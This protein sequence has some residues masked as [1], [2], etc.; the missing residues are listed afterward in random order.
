[1][2]WWRRTAPDVELGRGERQLDRLAFADGVLAVATTRRLVIRRPG[3]EDWARLWWQVEAVSVEAEERL[4]VVSDVEADHITLQLGDGDQTRFAAT[5]RERVQATLVDH[6]QLPVPGGSVRVAL[7]KAEG[8]LFLQEQWMGRVD[9]E[10]PRTRAVVVQL[11][12][13]LAS[14][15]SRP[16]LAG[17][18]V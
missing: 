3:R 11:R 16:E 10:D 18:A 5:L 14:A 6:R 12:Q 2:A 15:V 9:V 8:E 17:P 4:L 13:E 1:M 7:R